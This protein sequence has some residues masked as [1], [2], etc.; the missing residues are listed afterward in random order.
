MSEQRQ[1]SSDN[2]QEVYT[3]LLK[4]DKKHARFLLGSIIRN[5]PRNEKAWLMLAEAV[6][7]RNQTIYCL[8]RVLTINRRNALARRWLA[9]LKS[10][11]EDD[12]SSNL[13]LDTL[14]A[15]RPSQPTVVFSRQGIP[16]TPLQLA[17]EQPILTT[18]ITE[19]RD[20]IPIPG[21]SV[22]QRGAKHRRINW[23]LIFGLL[24]TFLVGIVALIGPS[25]APRDPL[26]E[27][28]IIKVG[29]KW[30]IPPFDP[31]TPGFPLGS[32]E[33]GRDLFSRL[34]W[35]VRPTMTLVLIVA[36]VR[37]TMGVLIGMV[38]GWSSGRL[39]HFLETL[40]ETS[41]SVPV[42][43]V[44]L[45]TIA[46]I[47]TELGIWAFIIGL[48]LTGWVE[49]A[50]QVSTQT[51]I[52]S[53]QVYIE[54]AR[55][56]GASSKSILF[57]H[58]LRQITP[59]LLMLYAFEVSNTLMVTAGLG[60]LGYYIGGDVW[61]DV[62]DFVARRISG[63]PELGQMLATSWSTLTRPW[64]MVSVGNVVFI[65][66][67]GFNLIGEGL[68]LRLQWGLAGRRDM[69]AQLREKIG[70]WID[71]NL[72]YPI[73]TLM[74]NRKARRA[75][76]LSMAIVSCFVL[77]FYMKTHLST[78][79]FADWLSMVQPNPQDQVERS[80]M[81]TQSEISP[82]K[83]KDQTGI[84]W[85]FTIPEKVASEMLPRILENGAVAVL[86]TEDRL[87]IINAEGTLR[88]QFLLHPGPFI[89]TRPWSAKGEKLFPAILTDGSVIVVSGEQ[90][91]YALD[92]KGEMLWEEPLLEKPIN[93]PPMQ[94]DTGQVYVSD[95]RG[96]LYAFD[97]Q[98]LR[99]RFHSEIAPYTL[100]NPIIGKNGVIY[101]ATTDRGS[102]FI[103]ALSPEGK[104][105]WVNEARTL[106]FYEGLQISP[107]NQ[108]LFLQEDIFDATTG[109]L[110]DLESPMKIDH[111]LIG[112]DHQIYAVSKNC[113][114]E[115][116][117]RAGNLE[118][119]QRDSCEI[120]TFGNQP[121]LEIVVDEHHVIWLY[122]GTYRGITQILWM[123]I[124]GETLGNYKL[125]GKSGYLSEADYKNTRY[126]D[127]TLDKDQSA[128][129]CETHTPESIQPTWKAVIKDIPEFKTGLIRDGYAYFITYENTLYKVS[130]GIP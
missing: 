91:V 130:L 20:S 105:L 89:A 48:S 98:G 39:G 22:K 75:F 63:M 52:V 120:P 108:Y 10:N 50:Q 9:S 56:L 7:D 114:F 84:V 3:A 4:G 97:S 57:Q 110:L 44:A 96:G 72:L 112:H 65:T 85:T 95:Q 66:V 83:L 55:A 45:G 54:A 36:T 103:H 78:L 101:F 40:I 13:I 19:V 35:A 99:F 126:T 77:G 76:T 70:L 30:Y 116:R 129:I 71:Q 67:L 128:L 86:T 46:L 14:L 111:Y 53:R 107:D 58:I 31:L 106:N 82:S 102:A 90:T 93:E 28:L 42:L 34:L 88:S 16:T 122:F 94:T 79:D 26:E 61:V 49:T 17:Q 123:S 68:R 62:S 73:H 25:L 11:R 32:D 8:E 125:P 80:H 115:V 124:S 81:P 21:I 43:L 87:V 60:F 51:R 118:I 33:Y 64:A 121:P 15:S 74:D 5:D 47:G 119:I 6:D 41:L 117:N 1:L 100:S 69:L 113:V 109:A 18:P 27:N 29:E 12:S 104:L 37:L 2:W 23:A 24:I 38:T 59:M 92:K 127:C